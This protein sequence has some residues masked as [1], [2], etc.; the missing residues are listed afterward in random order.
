[1]SRTVNDNSVSISVSRKVGVGVMSEERQL[2]IVGLVVV[3]VVIITVSVLIGFGIL[4]MG[5]CI[6]R[7]TVKAVS[8]LS[9]TRMVDKVADGITYLF[10][11]VSDEEGGGE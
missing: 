1:M 10:E 4:R 9:K 3:W 7:G 8:R 5:G 2:G 6:G 11:D